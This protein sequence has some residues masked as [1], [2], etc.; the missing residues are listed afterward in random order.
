MI[1]RLSVSQRFR[2]PLEGN[3]SIGFYTK[4]GLLL[5]K[6]YSRIVIGGR[7]PY[8]E[9]ET[10][11]IIQDNIFVPPH[12]EHKLKNDYSY[13]NEYRSKDKCWVKLYF[14]KM[15]VSYA[16]YKIGKWYID[17]TRVKT[18]EFEDLMLPMYIEVEEKVEEI[19]TPNLFDII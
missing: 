9:F 6:G 7:G 19:K 4:E 15:E 17:P 8:I 1:K 2:I 10:S 3:S 14:Q 16:D 5:A 18:N 11:N 13:Y 12:A